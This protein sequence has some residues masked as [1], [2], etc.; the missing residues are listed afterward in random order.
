MF[1]NTHF[2]SSTYKKNITVLHINISASLIFTS[3]R[4]HEGKALCLESLFLWASLT[5]QKY[6]PPLECVWLSDAFVSQVNW[7]EH[8]FVNF[9]FLKHYKEI[10]NDHMQR[11][12]WNAG[13]YSDQSRA[14]ID[15]LSAALERHSSTWFGE[16]RCFHRFL[17]HTHALL[18]LTKLNTVVSFHRWM[19]KKI[20][21]LM[22]M[23]LT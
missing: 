2:K 10:D 22:I 15:F 12:I 1:A 17:L 8:G 7:A 18:C 13:G 16:K 9:L 4:S 21:T 19:R 3:V 14:F 20:F 6:Q 5:S 11:F 23:L